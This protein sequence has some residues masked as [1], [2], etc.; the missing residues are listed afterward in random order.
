[1]ITVPEEIQ[2]RFFSTI[3]IDY[4]YMERSVNALPLRESTMRLTGHTRLDWINQSVYSRVQDRA[5]VSA[6]DGIR[7]DRWLMM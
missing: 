2:R 6:G 4:D 7:R 1:M 3:G 5:R